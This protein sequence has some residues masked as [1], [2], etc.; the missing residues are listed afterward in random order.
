MTKKS[1]ALLLTALV[2]IALLVASFVV[3]DDCQMFVYCYVSP[4]TSFCID[5]FVCP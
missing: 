4:S 2:G 5:I 3:A 1:K